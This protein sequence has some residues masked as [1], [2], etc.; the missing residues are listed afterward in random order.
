MSEPRPTPWVRPLALTLAA[1][2]AVLAAVLPFVP[3]AYRPWNFAAFGAVGLFVAARGGRLGLPLALLLGLGAKL[4]FDLIQYVQ[5][6]G[7]DAEYDYL[8]SPLV[9]ACLAMYAVIGW[10]ALRRTGNPVWIAGGTFLG[11][12][13]FFLVTNFASWVGQSLPY[14]YTLGGLLNSYWMALPFWRDGT[15]LSDFVFTAALFG[16]HAVLV[17]AW[18]PAERLVPIPVEGKVGR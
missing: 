13:V 5:K 14:G 1:G 7:A 16:L 11:S 10:F 12:L 2:F 18:F 6:G 17:Q 8:P 15:L 3:E 9:Y 4:A